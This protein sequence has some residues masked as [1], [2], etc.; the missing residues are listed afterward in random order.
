MYEDVKNNKLLI[1]D[2]DL[3]GKRFIHYEGMSWRV[4]SFNPNQG[5]TDIDFGGTHPNAGLKQIGEQVLR[6]YYHDIKHFF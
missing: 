1:G 6:Q 2:F 3:R 4:Q 5:D